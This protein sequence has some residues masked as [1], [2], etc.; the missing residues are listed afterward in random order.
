[1]RLADVPAGSTVFVDANILIFALTNHP[2]HGAACTVFLD[3]AEHQQ[4]VAVT[5]THV[6]GEV[7][8][9]MMSIEA[10]DRFAWPVQGIANRLRRHP[11]EVQQLVK[12]RQALDEIN[13]A[14]LGILTIAV[15]LVGLATDV[16]RLTGLLYGDALIVAVMRDHGLTQLASF[17]ADFDRVPGLTRYSPA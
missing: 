6:L 8:H 1:M 17:D 12:P 11:S 5:S 10:A 3:R 4:I 7:V 16:S 14:G 9:R 2:T 13:A 15:P